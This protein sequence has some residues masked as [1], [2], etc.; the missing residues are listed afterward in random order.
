MNA[1]SENFRELIR[2]GAAER[3][4]LHALGARTPEASPELIAAYAANRAF[5]E[6]INAPEAL[7]RLS[8]GDEDALEYAVCFLEVYPL[9][10]DSGFAMRDLVRALRDTAIP[11]NLGKRLR[12]AFLAIVTH[13]ARDEM[14]HLRRLALRV[15]DQPFV[16]ALDRLAESRDIDTAENARS[17]ATYI[18][19]RLRASGDE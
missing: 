5:I 6:K 3:N 17:L 4:R 10:P 1:A 11:A 15:S 14:K 19:G 13:P 2:S 9:C 18:S 16:L 7:A 12:A 8:A